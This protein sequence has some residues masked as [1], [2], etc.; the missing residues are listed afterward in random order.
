[1]NV[2]DNAG[3]RQADAMYTS[4]E[5][6]EAVLAAYE[7]GYDAGRAQAT[8]E[9]WNSPAVAE[10]LR[11]ERIAANMATMRRHA[12]KAYAARGMPYGYDYRGGAVDWNTGMPAGSGCAWLR[13]RRLTVSST[14]V[15][16]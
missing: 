2:N 10:P 13:R 11:V 1:L 9:H 16:A 5:L 15:A 14:E 12:S 8:R 7:N 4:E 3:E 6:L